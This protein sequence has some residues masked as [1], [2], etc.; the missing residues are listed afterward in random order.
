MVCCGGSGLRSGVGLI[1]VKD[2][3]N[4]GFG[5][6]SILVVFI[7]LAEKILEQQNVGI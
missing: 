6:I 7:D 1:S 2:S 4:Y 3:E 5:H